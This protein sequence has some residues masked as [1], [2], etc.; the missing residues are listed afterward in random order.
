[1][2]KPRKFP[3]RTAVRW[4]EEHKGV[5][6][7]PDKPDVEVACPPEFGGHEGYWSAEDLFVAAVNTCIM[8]TFLS[9]AEKRGIPY[10]RLIQRILR[11]GLRWKPT[12]LA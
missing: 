11:L 2:L 8:T 6:S 5:I 10:D 9:L 7:S 4:T 12:R 1:M 3:Y